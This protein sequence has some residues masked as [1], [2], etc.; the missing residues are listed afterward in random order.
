MNDET[1]AA[2][3]AETVQRLERR[4]ARLEARLGVAPLEESGPAAAAMTA[5]G[6]AA[7]VVGV[8]N[9]AAAPARPVERDLEF[10]VGQNWLA[11]VGILVLTCGVGLALLLPFGDLPAF[12]PSIAGGLVAGAMLLL[13]QRWR[14]TFELVA[15]YFRGAG[16]ALLYFSALRLCLFG[17]QHVLAIDSP[18]AAVLLTVVVAANVTMALRL[19]SP[20]LLGVALVT[21]LVTV[22]AVG[23][24]YLV[25]LGIALLLA[26]GAYAAV[27]RG[28]TW[29]PVFLIPA[30]YA[31]HLLWLVNRP[32]AGRG[33]EILG[34]PAA[35]LFAVLAYVVINALGSLGRR[36]RSAEDPA[37]VFAVLLNC[38]GYLLLVLAS[39]NAGPALFATAHLLATVVFLGL[40][41][42]FWHRESSRISTFCYAMTGYLALSA[43]LVRLVGLPELFI[44]L[45]WQSLLVV[46]TALWFR[47]K[48]IVVGNF[49][50]Y[51][52][53][54]IAYMVVST[55]ESGIS[56]GLGIVALL[57]ARILGWQRERLELQTGMMRNAYLA[58]AFIVFPYAL[59]HLVP[60]AFVAVSWV[61][62]AITYYLM[63]LIVHSRKYRWMGHFTLLLTALYV[64][65]FGIF[66]LEG[67]LRI[68]SF[69]LLGTVL[70]VVS[71]IFTTVRARRR[72]TAGATG[73]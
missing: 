9:G 73:T 11:S 15:G 7:V 40:A 45:S 54:V 25:F 27:T 67:T 19:C 4:L 21:G 53:I 43:A 63:N 68:G 5:V 61:G 28:W 6:S 2:T 31:T 17:T 35:G 3:L 47:S 30:G 55:S 59:Y 48:L 66:Q 22:V 10:V 57:T 58:S 51:A 38:G 39:M 44:W 56:L 71:L 14:T 42:A 65:V 36:D 69:L 13:A 37:T 64:I 16:M 49:F 62:V 33:F 1:D 8:G 46:A 70:M 12:V 34:R 20:W 24:P 32:W 72:R 29:L 60:R 50:I 41:A 23:A 18:A 52:S 26:L